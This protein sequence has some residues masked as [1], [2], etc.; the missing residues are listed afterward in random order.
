MQAGRKH[1]VLCGFMICNS[2]EMDLVFS[3]Q[4]D[5]FCSGFVCVVQELRDLFAGVLFT[6]EKKVIAPLIVCFHESQ[7]EV[8]AVVDRQTLLVQPWDHL[9]GVLLLMKA[10]TEAKVLAD[11]R[12]DIVSVREKGLGHVTFSVLPN[13]S[14]RETR[15]NDLSRSRQGEHLAVNGVDREAKPGLSVRVGFCDELFKLILEEEPGDAGSHSTERALMGHVLQLK[16]PV[17]DFHER[18][19][20]ALAVG[21]ADEANQRMEEDPGVEFSF[22]RES[23]FIFPGNDVFFMEFLGEVGEK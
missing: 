11:A 19:R 7:A 8:Q 15:R 13:G 12:N 21:S 4:K 10:V 1:L 18:M 22:A 5:C 9:P 23:G 2:N 14:A 6:A 17:P 16:L 20:V 3:P